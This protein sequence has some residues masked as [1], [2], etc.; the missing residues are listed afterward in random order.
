M[1]SATALIDSFISYI[2]TEKKTT[3]QIFMVEHAPKEYW[4]ENN[5][6]NFHTVDEFIN[7]DGLIPSDIYNE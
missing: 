6:L 2:I 1:Q 3:F 4:N 7:G 5:L